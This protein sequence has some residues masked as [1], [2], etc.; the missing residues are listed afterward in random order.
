MPI[1]TIGRIVHYT[2]AEQDA[3]AI[4]KR[5]TDASRQ[6][7]THREN[8]NGVQVH[9]GNAVSVGDVY[10]MIITCVWGTTPESSV[11]GQVFLDGNDLLWVTSVACGEGQRTF[12]WPS[13]VA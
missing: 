4:N 9:V 1:P 10:P 5:R 13:R 11:N 12:A 8:S 7:Q 6:M 3:Q 2:L